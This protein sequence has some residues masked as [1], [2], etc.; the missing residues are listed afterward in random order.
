MRSC[1]KREAKDQQG[2][3]WDEGRR[4]KGEEKRRITA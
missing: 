4:M 3:R 2:G 1:T